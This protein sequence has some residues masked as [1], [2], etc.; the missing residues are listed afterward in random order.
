[1]DFIW[2]VICDLCDFFPQPYSAPTSPDGLNAGRWRNQGI[3]RACLKRSTHGS[4]I[5]TII[6]GM[7]VKIMISENL[8]VDKPFRVM[9]PVLP[10]FSDS[11]FP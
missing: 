7:F 5:H 3:R 1:M 8:L 9:Q 11:F 10:R 2:H 6:I 4:C